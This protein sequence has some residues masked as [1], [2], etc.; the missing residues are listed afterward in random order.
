LFSDVEKRVMLP[1]LGNPKYYKDFTYLQ[2]D[3]KV[4]RNPH[5]GWYWHYIDN[6]ISRIKKGSELCLYRDRENEYNIDDFPGMHHLYLRIDWSDIEAQEGVFDW[7]EIDSI[8][9]KYG[10]RGYKF[11]LRLCTYEGILHDDFGYATPKWVRD[12]GAEGF[13]EADG[14]WQPK[15]DD[16]IYLEKLENFFKEFG[17]KYGTHPLVEYVDIGTLGIWGEGNLIERPS[18]LS[19]DMDMF[20]K[21][22][23]LHT[24]YFP[25]K[26]VLLNDDTANSAGAN[27]GVDGRDFLDY[28]L[29]IGL[30]FRDDS[31]IVS[32][33]ADDG[34]Y[35]YHTL[36]T[37]FMFDLFAENAP[38]DIE[39]GHYSVSDPRHMR[40]GFAVYEVLRRAHAT[41]CGFHT[42]PQDWYRDFPYL[43]EHLANKLGYW[44]FV[45]GAEI[46]KLVSG[47]GAIVSVWFENKGFSKA[48]N[49]FT[50]KF[51]LVGESGEYI[52]FENDTANLN[53]KAES[54]TKETFKF[55]LT[56]VPKGD[57]TLCVGLFE[58]ETNIK[59]GFKSACDRADGYYELTGVCVE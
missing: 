46:P 32:C 57:Y 52:V 53:W 11:T 58:N 21:H 31:A 2:D 4:L 22:I 28:C 54:V 16:P 9:E 33:Y 51:K 7:S 25:D 39:L 36:R 38:V 37:P 8:I 40:D 3:I 34:Y 18:C 45:N 12:L 43:T 13:D 44:Y 59:M 30:G 1:I 15:Y 35:G 47:T 55:N 48:Y 41:Y 19:Y 10:K 50:L 24:K 6:G 56:N 49:P 17:R 27:E 26:F 14:S 42:Y 20:R 5:K 29:G 23:E